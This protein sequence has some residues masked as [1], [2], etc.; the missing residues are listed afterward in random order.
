MRS[1]VNPESPQRKT[2]VPKLVSNEEVGALDENKSVD[3]DAQEPVETWWS[4]LLDVRVSVFL[5]CVIVI[6]MTA[7][8][9]LN[10]GPDEEAEQVAT[11]A[12]SG[13]VSSDPVSETP[14]A[15]GEGAVVVGDLLAGRAMVS[16]DPEGGFVLAMKGAKRSGCR[17]ETGKISDWESG[18]VAEW[19]IKL[20]DRRS[21]FFRC[22][23]TYESAHE[24]QLGLQMGDRSPRRFSIYP[25]DGV[26]T[27]QFIVRLDKSDVQAVKLMALEEQEMDGVAILKLT[28]T[29]MK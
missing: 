24:C 12:G 25:Q 10:R 2:P 23:V 14:P 27:E 6:A 15:A 28:L 20:D 29:P 19:V 11:P 17:L 5:V 16:Q 4:D 3:A 26:F 8:V 9:L 22:H 1:F 18:G 21:G 13:A 7:T